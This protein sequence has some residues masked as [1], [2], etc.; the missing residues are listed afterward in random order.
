MLLSTAESV[1]L[2][3][4]GESVVA[5]AIDGFTFVV[6]ILHFVIWRFNL[7]D[8]VSA[9]CSLHYKTRYKG[10]VLSERNFEQRKQKKYPKFIL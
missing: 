9:A 10:N 7:K 4:V 8:L 5:I 2:T 1:Q 3:T 6:P